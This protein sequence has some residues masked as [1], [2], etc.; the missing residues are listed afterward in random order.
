[1]ITPM[2]NE[3]ISFMYLFT[4]SILIKIMKIKITN[5]FYLPHI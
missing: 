4:I 2:E 1:M 5:K 3:I